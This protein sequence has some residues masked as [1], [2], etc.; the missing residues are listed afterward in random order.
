MDHF[1]IERKNEE[2]NYVLIFPQIKKYVEHLYLHPF[3]SDTTKQNPF[4][5]NTFCN[6]I[7]LEILP[8]CS[9]SQDKLRIGSQLISFIKVQTNNENSIRASAKKPMLT[10]KN[11]QKA[12]VNKRQN[13]LLFMF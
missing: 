12:V 13:I 11:P 5:R 2:L 6:L 3:Y 10:L 8:Y 9:F 4:Y 7:V 1:K